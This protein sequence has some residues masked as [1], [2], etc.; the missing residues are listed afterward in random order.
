MKKNYFVDNSDKSVTVATHGQ[1]I[2]DNIGVVCGQAVKLINSDDFKALSTADRISKAK[3]LM[4]SLYDEELIADYAFDAENNVMKFTYKYGTI[5]GQLRPAVF[6]DEHKQLAQNAPSEN[7]EEISYKIVRLPDK[8]VYKLGESINLKGIQ[9]EV[10]KDNEE[11]V[12]YAY[13]DVAFDYQSNIPKPATVVISGEYKNDK[14]GTVAI[15]AVG[16]DDVLFTVEFVDDSTE[17]TQENSAMLTTESGD[18]G[19]YIHLDLMSGTFSM[20]GSI[21][22]NFAVFG[23]FERKGNDLYLYAEYG[24]TNVYVLHREDDHFISQS[25]ESVIRL[26]KGLVFSA[27]NDVFWEKL[28]STNESTVK[29]DANCDGKV[30]LADAILIMQSL[31]NPNKYGI[32]G[33]AEHH[34]TA[35]GRANADMNG[36]GLTVDDALAIQLKLL[37]LSDNASKADI[38]VFG[39]APSK[40][41]VEEFLA[42]NP[43]VKSSYQGDEL[44]NVTPEQITD[45]YNFRIFKYSS[46]CESYLEYNGK[47]YHIGTGFGGFGTV[48]FAVADIDSNGSPELYFTYSF[49]SGI[50]ASDISYFDFATETVSELEFY[51]ERGLTDQSFGYEVRDL[52]FAVNNNRLEIYSAVTNG[53]SFVN[54]EVELK[55]KLGEITSDSG[56]I[57]AA[58]QGIDSSLIANKLFIYEKETALGA[59][60]ISFG[61]NGNYYCNQGNLD[62]ARDIGKWTISGDTVVLTG[63]FGTNRFSFKDD[64]LI[65]IAE[66]SDGFNDF[67]PKD[68]EK[69]TLAPERTYDAKIMS[70]NGVTVSIK[71]DFRPHMSDMSGIGILIEVDS[72]DFPI[73]LKADDGYFRIDDT[74]KGTDR[75]I[76]V[77]KTCEAG[78]SGRVFWAPDELYYQEGFESEIQVIGVSGDV[79]ID[80]GRIY[81]AQV[82][83]GIFEASFEKSGST[84]VIA[85]NTFVYEKEGTGSEFT[86]TFNTDG[87]FEYYTG[88]LSSYLG[89]GTWEI[90]DDT[91]TMT[92]STSTKVNYLKINGSDLIYIA[93]GSDNFYGIRVKDGEKFFVKAD[94]ENSLTE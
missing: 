41:G 79:F 3:E 40:T 24:S 90:K 42:D 34:L 86:I 92:E 55:E 82:K 68:G 84:A 25:D 30:D 66:G 57:K 73:T 2:F 11:P 80:L 12:I 16:S 67:K 28:T 49:G 18:D 29:G 60:D 10:K 69:F 48:S 56:A 76:N 22:Q 13:P 72:P 45:R 61:D 14:V 83:G 37:G 38:A 64:A 59:Y 88:V 91:V 43:T 32:D 21:Y 26:T 8:T 47:T 1:D 70:I 75:F 31:A 19:C 53:N 89:A 44:F 52:A 5:T 9:V 62:A 23:K 74:E 46:D 27:E 51:Y 17:K 85:G 33:T 81:V 63:K 20:S 78:K 94:S 58:G 93:E 39:L 54:L 7:T 71:S 6:E 77:G 65:Y 87:T 4:K 36:D 50:H 35:Q 15:K